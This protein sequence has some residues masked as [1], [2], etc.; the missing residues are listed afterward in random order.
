MIWINNLFL[1]EFIV[2]LVF[3][4]VINAFREH[5]RVWIEFVCQI[6]NI[7]GMYNFF[8]DPNNL[9]EYNFYEKIFISVIFIR[10]LKM[11]TLFYEVKS[12]R[13]IIETMKNLLSPITNM[14]LVLF[15]VYWIFAIFGMY[16]YGGKIRKNLPY[17]IQ[18]GTNTVPAS[19]HL[20]NFND[21]IS[22]MVTLFTLMVVNNWMVQVS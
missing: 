2:D 19:Y 14:T 8:S 21:F 3:F 20:D 9:H 16:L 12:L 7:Y 10:A 4:G 18:Q 22:S 13:I 11:L 15:I 5:F 6:V 17:P 1:F